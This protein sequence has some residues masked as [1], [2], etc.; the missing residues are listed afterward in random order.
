MA[1]VVEE[2]EYDEYEEE[3]MEDEYEEELEDVEEIDADG[4]EEEAIGGDL[5]A[6]GG[7]AAARAAAEDEDEDYGDEGEDEEGEEEEEEEEEEDDL[8]VAQD[9]AGL[10]TLPECGAVLDALT[11][12][13]EASG[14]RQLTVLLLGKSG[15]GK[16]SL[17]NALLGEK[18]AA[19]SAFK[20]QADTES[21][22]KFV[23]QVSLG[24]DALDGFRL[25]LIDT[26]GLEDPEAGDT[27]SYGALQRI[28]ED[29]R[30][31][32]ID[33]VL[34]CDRLDLYRVE[35]LDKR[36]ISAITDQFG[37][38][39]WSKTLLVLSHG[40]LGLPPPGCSYE[41]FSDRRVSL[42]RG[43]VRGP[44][45][46]PALPAVIVENSDTCQVDAERCRVLPDGTRWV[47]ELLAAL[48]DTALL[49]RPYSW[50]PRLSR[51]PN[52]S[53]KWLI[54][55][56]AYA[57]YMVWKLLLEPRL[58]KDEDLQAAQDEE[59]WREKTAERRRLGIGPP[60]RPSGENAWR[61][62]QLYDDD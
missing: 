9:W 1:R 7:A 32:P 34:Y 8:V 19:V 18:A 58:R 27:V 60:L 25:T 50:R 3:E 48:V 36:I 40:Q 31:A 59:I 35:P 12:I 42:L 56:A 24:D 2:P 45:F 13:A 39:I 17:V 16:S 4:E 14:G 11:R 29:V 37:K 26:C 30:G 55:V 54:P 47:D 43:A 6:A 23:R 10:R 41:S 53:L 52:N 62:E 28:A 15:V 57:Q 38:G 46:R 5:L 22:V 33:A 51:R 49:G 20:L 21:T 61:L 44:F